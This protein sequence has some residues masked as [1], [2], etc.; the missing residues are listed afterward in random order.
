MQKTIINLSKAF[1]GESQAR[2]RYTI[3]SKIAKKEG[4]EQIADIFLQTAEQEREHAKWLFRLIN[5]LKKKSDN[6]GNF[7]EIKIESD[8]STYYGDTFT[9]LKAAATGEN[10]EYTTMYPDFADIAEQEGLV[11]I[12]KRLR[13]IAVAEKHHEQRYNKLLVELEN[14]TVFK[15]TDEIYWVCR[16][17]GYLHKGNQAPNECPSC[18][19]PTAYFEKQNEEY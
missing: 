17:C 13:A 2:N 8:V 6:P 16:K 19:H 14:N 3:Y 4:Y 15:K 9:N 1:V 18:G 7:E 11:D 12:A 5:D 10:Y